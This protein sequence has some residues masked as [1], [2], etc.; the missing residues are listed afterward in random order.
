[1][2]SFGQ[3]LQRAI[4]AIG[5]SRRAFAKKVAYSPT[6][7]DAIVHGRRPPPRKHIERWARALELTGKAREEFIELGYLVHCPPYIQDRYR[8]MRERP[9]F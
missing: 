5:L 7:M 2:D 3:C 9:R 6:S 8:A 1:M 4:V